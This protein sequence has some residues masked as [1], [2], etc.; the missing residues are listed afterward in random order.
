MTHILTVEEHGEVLTLWVESGFKDKTLVCFDRHLDFKPVTVIP[1]GTIASSCRKIPFEDNR[2]SSYGLDDFLDLAGRLGL[3]RRLI[4]VCPSAPKQCLWE[5]V[6]WISGYGKQVKNTWKSLP[7]GARVQLRRMVIEAT[8]LERLSLVGGLDDAVLDIDLD[9]FCDER[10]RMEIDP[11]QWLDEVIGLGLQDQVFA[12]C[13]SE[14]SGFIPAQSRHLAMALAQGLERPLYSRSCRTELAPRTMD[15]IARRNQEY[16]SL[17]LLIEEE[18]A[19]LGGPGW[20][21]ASVA[22][23]RLGEIAQAE[24]CYRKARELGDRA[25][26]AAFAIAH[27]YHRDHNYVK[28]LSWSKLVGGPR[29]D[30]MWARS[31]IL[32]TV[33]ALRSGQ[34][35]IAL[36]LATKLC[37]AIPLRPE[38]FE[39]VRLATAQ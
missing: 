2:L 12:L 6:S 4:W 33:A 9:Y 26:W 22:A 25:R 21:L 38:P 1:K 20:S 18:L 34:R 29:A 7:Y 37:E 11:N 5:H 10:G 3:V 28:A 30:P 19:V 35:E 24:I 27:A 16:L 39:L 32:G 14:R 23:C 36:Y 17:D 31:R 8:T 15:L 13:F